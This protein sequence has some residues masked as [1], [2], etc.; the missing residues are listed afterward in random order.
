ML[1][2]HYLSQLAHTVA[3]FVQLWGLK[4]SSIFLIWFAPA[5]ETLLLLIFFVIIDCIT[6]IW[7]AVEK[8]VGFK[9]KGLVPT[10][11]KIILYF[12]Y[13]IVCHSFQIHFLKDSFQIFQVLLA[14]PI[15]RELTSIVENIESLTGI[16]VAKQF[17]DI[18]SGLFSKLGSKSIDKE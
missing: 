5:N 11:K 13:C 15:I 6:G 3:K 16:N 17:K 4:L 14:I 10:I 12:I 2:L 1:Y 9:S 8:G 18:L 7:V